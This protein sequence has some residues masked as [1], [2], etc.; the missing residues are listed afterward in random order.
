MKTASIVCLAGVL[1]VA[2]LA[3]DSAFA[4]SANN[5]VTEY[6]RGRSAP[7]IEPSV[8]IQANAS[9]AAT[10]AYPVLQAATPKPVVRVQQKM[11]RPRPVR[12]MGPVTMPPQDVLLT[13]IRS[14]LS[15]VNQANFTDNYSVL[16]GMGT[17]AL[18]ARVSLAQFGRAFAQLRS[19]NL[20]LSA[21]LVLDPQFSSA[22]VL[23]PGGAL[24]LQ[25]VFPSRPHQIS[26]AIDY[27]P[28]DGYWLIDSLSVSALQPETA[29]SAAN[30]ANRT[31]VA[32]ADR[33]TLPAGQLVPASQSLP[34][35]K[36]IKT[37]SNSA[38]AIGGPYVP[39]AY[40]QVSSQR[41]EAEAQAA[42][43]ALQKRYPDI[44]RSHQTAVRSANVGNKGTY[45]RAQ[46]GPVSTSQA[47]QIC[48]DLK[49][50]GAECFVQ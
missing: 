37:G 34:F 32:S 14:T 41:S 25:G 23:M 6:S 50:V 5:N 31:V 11:A 2:V 35:P 3:T 7:P 46:I 49:A 15:A 16:H 44:F 4:Q 8:F 29:I 17:P 9:N 26:F 36:L 47:K 48:G 22:P 43:N 39:G 40:V 21:A 20:D 28:V 10:T 12:S 27:L 24:K 38:S 45:Y 13:M 42:L 1:A 30:P 19:Q 18:Q 33:G